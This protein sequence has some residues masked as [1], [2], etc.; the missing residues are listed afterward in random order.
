M[1]RH[2]ELGKLGEE[3]AAIFLINI[4][5][6]ILA[7]NYRFGRAEV[8]IIATND[9]HVIFVEV[10]TR[11]NYLY[12]YP[13]ESVGAKKQKL[14]CKAASEYMY[15]NNLNIAIRF[16]VMAIFKTNNG[17]WQIQHLEDAFFIYE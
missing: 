4:G 12:G 1:G 15:Q 16:D 11:T 3:K 17:E 5:Y 14:M 7:T 9:K 6:R 13:E 8:D 2:N 10:K